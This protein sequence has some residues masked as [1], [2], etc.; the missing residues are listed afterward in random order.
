VVEIGGKA[1]RCY[2]LDTTVAMHTAKRVLT[3]EQKQALLDQIVDSTEFLAQ[4]RRDG[5]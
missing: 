2:S 4:K 3:P 1:E 5:K